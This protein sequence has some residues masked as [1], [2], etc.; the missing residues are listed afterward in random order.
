M[1]APGGVTRA[2]GGELPIRIAESCHQRGQAC[3]VLAIEEFALEVPPHLAS[4]RVPIK[5]LGRGFAWLDTGTPDSLMEAASFVQALEKRQGYS[6]ACPEEVAFTLGYIT[7]DDLARLARDY[8]NSAYGEYLLKV[9][10][11]A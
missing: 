7:G 10:A 11:M 2:G 8:A 5:K 4:G 9:R 1:P 6:I 3:F